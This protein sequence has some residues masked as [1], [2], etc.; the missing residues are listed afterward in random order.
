VKQTRKS[1]NKNVRANILF[2][3]YNITSGFWPCIAPMRCAH[4]SVM[5]SR[6]KYQT[7]QESE[8]DRLERVT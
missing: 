6:C 7:D 1:G 4:K 5:G 2:Y 8:R 3:Y